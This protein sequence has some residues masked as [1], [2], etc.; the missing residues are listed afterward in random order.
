MKSYLIQ[1][2]KENACEEE[3]VNTLKIKSLFPLIVFSWNPYWQN[4]G[5]SHYLTLN[6]NNCCSQ[7]Q[8]KFTV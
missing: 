3:I 4:S 5:S 7:H 1:L 8:H 2:T 6:N